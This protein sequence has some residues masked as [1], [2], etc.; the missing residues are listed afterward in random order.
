MRHR[1]AHTSNSLQVTQLAAK[2]VGLG[3]KQA[4][5]DLRLGKSKLVVVSKNLPP[6]VMAELQY[7][8]MLSRTPLHIY[9]GTNG[10]LGAAVGKFHRVAAMTISDVGESDMFTKE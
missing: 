2:G 7:Y 5:R 6:V 10:Q 4:R 9:M 8:C 3:L 1:A